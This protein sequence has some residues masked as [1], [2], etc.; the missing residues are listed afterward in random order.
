MCLLWWYRGI[1]VSTCGQLAPARVGRS[2]AFPSICGRL[3]RVKGRVPDGLS[4]S[5]GISL[6]NWA[7]VSSPR[8]GDSSVSVNRAR[9]RQHPVDRDSPNAS[10]VSGGRGARAAARAAH[11][12]G[13]STGS[14]KPPRHRGGSMCPIE[15]RRKERNGSQC[16]RRHRPEAFWRRAT[17]LLKSRTVAVLDQ[18]H[19]D[20]MAHCAWRPWRPLGLVTREE[21]IPALRGERRPPGNGVLNSD[22][23]LSDKRRENSSSSRRIASRAPPRWGS[24]QL[25]SA[26]VSGV[27]RVADGR[28]EQDVTGPQLEAVVRRAEQARRPHMVSEATGPG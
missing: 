17:Q 11:P 21:K 10:T 19:V 6:A 23:A 25:I 12:R 14:R 9:E 15:S 26:Q 2:K 18:G 7:N 4:L 1:C 8:L 28:L 24:A 16:C 22:V 3:R 13:N 20:G 5:S 27:S